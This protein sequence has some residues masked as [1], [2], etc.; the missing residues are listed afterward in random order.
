MKSGKS[1]R[2]WSKKTKRQKNRRKGNKKMGCQPQKNLRK[3]KKER[4][5]IKPNC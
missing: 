4:K 1:P 2:K 5:S 3:R